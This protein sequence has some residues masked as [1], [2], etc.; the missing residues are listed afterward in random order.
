VYSKIDDDDDEQNAYTVKYFA[1]ILAKQ[2][3]IMGKQ[4]KKANHKAVICNFVFNPR[5]ELMSSQDSTGLEDDD[6]FEHSSIV[7]RM[8]ESNSQESMNSSSSGGS[9]GGSVRTGDSSSTF[10]GGDVKYGDELAHFTDRIGNMHTVA[11][12]PWKV[13]KTNG[14]GYTPAKH[15]SMEG[16]KCLTRAFCVQCN[17]PYCFGLRNDIMWKSTTDVVTCFA[18][19]VK[20]IRRSSRRT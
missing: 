2:L 13:Q 3:L 15:C 4:L 17:K 10:G 5:D 12:Y 20:D 16:C 11:K 6:E 8:T 1:G 18:Q 9:I 7:S 14:K 19:H